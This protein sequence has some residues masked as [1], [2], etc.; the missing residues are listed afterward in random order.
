MCACWPRSTTPGCEEKSRRESTPSFG[1]TTVALLVWA[2]QSSNLL[3]VAIDYRS[4]EQLTVQSVES[5]AVLYIDPIDSTDKK[6]SKGQ[7][8]CLMPPFLFSSTVVASQQPRPRTIRIKQAV[9]AALRQLF[10]PFII[11]YAK[12]F[13]S[14][15][16]NI[17]KTDRFASRFTN[18]VRTPK[19]TP[20]NKMPK[21][22][23]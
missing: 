2:L 7:W 9:E 13:H 6:P 15:I 22:T 3:W 10:S 19:N 14:K 23:G 21:K 12:R 1:F 16:G 4:G 18:I 11:V 5:K 20:K 17:S 8:K